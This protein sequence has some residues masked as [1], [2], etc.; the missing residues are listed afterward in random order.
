MVAYEQLDVQSSCVQELLVNIFIQNR[1]QDGRL[2][3]NLIRKK[4]KSLEEAVGY[5]TK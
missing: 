3:W 1:M 2:A 4:L 5:A